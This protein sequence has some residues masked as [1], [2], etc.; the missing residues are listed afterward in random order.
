MRLPTAAFAKA[1]HAAKASL[2]ACLCSTSLFITPAPMLAAPPTMNEAIIEFSEALHPILA[3][4]NTATPELTEQVAALVFSSVEPAKM[5]KAIDAS[6]D[7]LTS[8]PADTIST[9]TGIVK[10]QFS[11]QVIESC[12]VVP[13]PPKDLVGKIAKTEALSLVDKTKLSALETAWGPTL[14]LLPKSDTYSVGDET[15]SVICLPPPAALGQLALAQADVGRSI[16]AAELKRFK[17]VVPA[18]LQVIKPTDAIPLAKTAEQL[19]KV[20]AAQQVRLTS[21]RKAVEKAAEAEAYKA[22]LAEINA[23]SAAAKAQMDA[24]NAAAKAPK[25]S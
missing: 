22:R 23:R 15:F 16:G 14:K 5:A 12:P 24:K 21:A 3:N 8:V 4:L 20:P 11:G 6:I 13:L 18:T 25:A 2:L 17:E 19:A 7:A 10:E 9:F 1:E